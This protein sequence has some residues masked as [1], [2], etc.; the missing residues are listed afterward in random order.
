MKIAVCIK[1]VPDSAA[2]RR[3]DPTSGRLVREGDQVLNSYDS[4]AVEAALQLKESGA[5]V[6]TPR[7]SR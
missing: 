6:R 1:E 5:D 2:P 4:H 3:L 7:W